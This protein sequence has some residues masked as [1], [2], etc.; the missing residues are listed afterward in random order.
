MKHVFYA[1]V[2][3][4][5]ATTPA[6]ST[7][8][9]VPQQV[10]QQKLSFKDRILLKV[11]SLKMKYFNDKS[12]TSN[13]LL[14]DCAKI[15]LKDG[16]VIE[17]NIIQITPIEV[18]YKRCG[19]PNDPET[20]LYKKDILSIKASDGEII[21]RNTGNNTSRTATPSTQT[22]NDGPSYDGYSIASLVTGISGLVLFG[23]WLGLAAGICGIV[24]GY[25]G[26]KRINANP[27]M[28]KGKNMARG[29]LIT[30]IIACAL[31]ALALASVIK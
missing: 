2:C 10:T 4:F 21:Y 25:M 1:M 7:V 9:T 14:G 17:A 11:L 5:L 3:L 26:L 28:Y 22:T 16:D 27:D 12:L 18:K 6:Y 13:D 19:K 15:V 24:F 31:F 23:T 29:G 8:Q 20:I 30:G